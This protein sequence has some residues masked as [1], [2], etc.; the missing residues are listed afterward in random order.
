MLQKMVL[1]K[2]YGVVELSDIALKQLGIESISEIERTDARLVGLFENGDGEKLSGDTSC[3]Q[4]VDVDMESDMDYLIIEHDG[5][6][7]VVVGRDLKW[8][9]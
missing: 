3:L 1:N 2:D 6:E 5:L 7:T 8:I 4:L 9:R